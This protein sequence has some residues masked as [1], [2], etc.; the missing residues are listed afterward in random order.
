MTKELVRGLVAVI[1][2]A[3]FP[4][5]VRADPLP[6]ATWNAVK[7]REVILLKL[8][9]SRAAGRL[10]SADG[11]KAVLSAPDGTVITLDKK[12]VEGIRLAE[13]PAAPV[14]PP[15]PALQTATPIAP[16]AVDSPQ[17]ANPARAFPLREPMAT[18]PGG[19][20][21]YSSFSAGPGGLFMTIFDSGAGLVLG[22]L[23]GRWA[24]P[25]DQKDRSL[26][27]LTA[28]GGAVV[29]GGVA[30]AYQ[31]LVWTNFPRALSAQVSLVSG[32]LLGAGILSIRNGA[33]ERTASGTDGLVISA[34]AE[35]SF[36]AFLG[37]THEAELTGSDTLCTTVGAIDGFVAAFLLDRF[38]QSIGTR[39]LGNAGL[40][41]APAIGEVLG[42]LFALGVRPNVGSVAMVGFIPLGITAAF[43][44]S[45]GMTGASSGPYYWGAT[46]GLWLVSSA[47]F[48]SIAASRSAEAAR[49]SVSPSASVAAASS[50]LEWMPTVTLLPDLTPGRGAVPGLGLAGRF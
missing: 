15:P 25:L 41:M 26:A 12:E 29:F 46:G 13:T 18:S 14:P 17:P 43:A 16:P 28:L 6:E 42:G 27:P 39:G 11:D 19:H 9:G 23:A 50:D 36:L 44:L 40:Y 10:L 7:D 34:V 22:G 30:A 47:V 5:L 33:W 21:R 1:G 35:A 20:P 45:L 24:T 31:Y 4:A 2:L 48:A 38:L 8:G 32:A 49:S 37:L 3:L